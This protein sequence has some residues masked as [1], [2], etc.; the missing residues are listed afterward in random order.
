MSLM[1]ITAL[2]LSTICRS[3]LPASG[4]VRLPMTPSPRAVS[5]QRQYRKPARRTGRPETRLKQLKP[6]APSG[7]QHVADPA[8][9]ADDL[10]L[11]RVVLELAA[12][13]GDTDVDGTVERAPVAVLGQVEQL[14][15]AQ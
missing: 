8:Q 7:H 14:I 3:G 11:F 13:P 5:V 9:G 4:Q 6:S 1:K 15:T 10:R 2:L 12:Q